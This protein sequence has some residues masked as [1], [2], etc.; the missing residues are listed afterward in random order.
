[1]TGLLSRIV[2]AQGRDDEALELTR[3]AEEATAED[4]FD[5]QALWRATRAPILARAGDHAVAEEL[6]RTAVELVS[7]TEA[8]T[9]RAD[10]LV[11]LAEVLR[12]AGRLEQARLAI[13]EANSLYA[14]KGDI[15]SSDRCRACNAQITSSTQAA[16]GQSTRPT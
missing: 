5:S 9:L 2:R 12:V 14:A 8:S 4:D 15:V 7:R 13:E 16:M 10:A 3:A 1:M 11:E 6:A